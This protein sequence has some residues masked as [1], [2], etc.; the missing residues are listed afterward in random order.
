MG[1]EGLGYG[2]DWVWALWR[3]IGISW[4]RS[5][6]LFWHVCI[7][8]FSRKTS[9]HVLYIIVLLCLSPFADITRAAGFFVLEE[10]STNFSK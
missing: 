6:A 2:W 3:Y 4:H 10:S 8:L 5:N 1:N 7:P 9:Y